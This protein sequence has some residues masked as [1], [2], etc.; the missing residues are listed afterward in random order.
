MRYSEKAGYAAITE[1]LGE[2]LASFDG[3]ESILEGL[4]ETVANLGGGIAF[5]GNLV[6][7]RRYIAQRRI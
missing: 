7:Y 5:P 2:P 6:E 4:C 1:I 3:V